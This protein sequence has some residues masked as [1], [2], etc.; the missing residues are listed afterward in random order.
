[1]HA[2]AAE[3]KSTLSIDVSQGPTFIYVASSL[4]LNGHLD[5]SGH[6]HDVLVAYVGGGTASVKAPFAGT[7]VAPRALLDLDQSCAHTD[8]RPC[9]GATDVFRGAFFAHDI[10]VSEGSIV[11]LD[12]SSILP[13]FAAPTP[14]VDC[15]IPGNA[16]MPATA[17]LG[18]TNTLSSP[19]RLPAGPGNAVSSAATGGRVPG[20]VFQPGVNH[21]AFEIPFYGT[22]L[23]WTLGGRT[24][25][26]IANASSSCNPQNFRFFDFPGL[27]FAMGLVETGH[28][29]LD[30]NGNPVGVNGSS[31]VV[32]SDLDN[33]AF[34]FPFTLPTVFSGSL[35][36]NV[37]QGLADQVFPSGNQ[38]VW[39]DL[40]TFTSGQGDGTGV[41]STLGSVSDELFQWTGHD[42]SLFAPAAVDLQLHG[43][44][45]G[46]TP[47]TIT[48]QD[49]FANE[50]AHPGGP[51]VTI[52]MDP[53]TLLV[54]VEVSVLFSPENPIDV[55]A[56]QSSAVSIYNL[57]DQ[58]AFWDGNPGVAGFFQATVPLKNGSTDI[59]ETMRLF[60]NWLGTVKDTNG[61]AVAFKKWTPDSI[62]SKCGIQFRLVNFIPI[63]T[64]NEHVLPIG[65]KANFDLCQAGTTSQNGNTYLIQILE[66]MVNR[67][68]THLQ[69]A[70][71]IAFSGLC[72]CDSFI[73]SDDPEQGARVVAGLLGCFPLGTGG[74]AAG[75]DMITPAHE[76][77]HLLGLGDAYTT[78]GACDPATGKGGV[79]CANDD[80]PVPTPAE[81]T[82]ARANAMSFQKFWAH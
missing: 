65:P 44:R 33:P 73:F 68:P 35:N 76:L 62:W 31:P 34:S 6:E 78:P 61:R 2:L 70:L 10:D 26:A 20:Q 53:N 77:G 18:Y 19:V 57:Q 36:A 80:L 46:Y 43:A 38:I 52:A 22:T 51:A 64:D 1:M 63:P 55:P 23:A 24:V 71:E 25:F 42:D 81:C 50:S 49:Q 72:T 17:V 48:P 41:V 37:A 30:P 67:A 58:F 27:T 45:V 74:G 12:P 3:E 13:V 28:V 82:A 69:G 9:V 14:V 11:S 39:G 21:D 60:P 8:H 32:F 5:A 16:G 40:R 47:L 79:M 29:T 56:G 75:G 66:N 59:E 54:P 4:V 15:V 7:V